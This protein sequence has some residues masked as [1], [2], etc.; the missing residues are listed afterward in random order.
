MTISHVR[1]ERAGLRSRRGIAGYAVAV[2]L[3]ASLLTGL[4]TGT[5]A[6]VNLPATPG[7]LWNLAYTE[8]YFCGVLW[9]DFD[10]EELQRALQ[11]FGARQRRF[12]LT[13]AQVAGG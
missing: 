13:S 8:L 7:L 12:G 11:H 6:A 2:G 10:D 1:E 4:R 3:S 9:P 5:F